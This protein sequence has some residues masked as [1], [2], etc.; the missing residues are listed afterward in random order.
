[1]TTQQISFNGKN[2]ML[3]TEAV[4]TGRLLPYP[5]NYHEVKA[6]EEFEFEM[7]AK[8]ADNEGVRY[9]V[10]WVFR[11]IKGEEADYDNY[12]FADIYDVTPL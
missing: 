2:Y 10:I 12:D 6:G 11:D 5:K 3:I 7:A 8:A 9:E 1:M 4:M